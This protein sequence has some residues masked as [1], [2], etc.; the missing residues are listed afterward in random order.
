M[1]N[2][3]TRIPEANIPEGK[4]PLGNPVRCPA[5][6]GKFPASMRVSGHT[7][8]L[9]SDIGALEECLALERASAQ[10][11]RTASGEGI[12]S[13]P[14]VPYCDFLMLRDSLGRLRAVTRLMKLERDMPMRNPLDSGRFHLSPLLTALRYSREGI[15]EM[16]A[17]A[18]AADCET[19]PAA[20]LLWAGLIRYLEWNNLHFVIGLDGLPMFT[21]STRTWPQLLEAHGLHPDLAV[22]TRTAYASRILQTPSATASNA[23]SAAASG[24][25]L[26]NWPAGLQ[27]A[28]LRGCRL[29]GEP[30]FDAEAGRLEFVW[31]ASLDMLVGDGPGDWSGGNR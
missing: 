24:F 23:V 29:A 7:L 17:P 30:A 22:E 19:A 26:R 5:P 21:E 16:G 15:L 8:T 31:V 12:H 28:L 10:T 14:A 11:V 20:R 3:A 4:N 9:A 27:E 2:N 6:C 25:S 18:F 13:P 1:K